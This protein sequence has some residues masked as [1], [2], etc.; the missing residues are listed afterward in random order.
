MG[1][2]KPSNPPLPLKLML[3]GIVLPGI[4]LWLA[5][6]RAHALAF[7]VSVLA[8]TTVGLIV[9]GMT[10]IDGNGHPVYWAMQMFAGLPVWLVQAM[11]LNRPPL[12]GE[13]VGVTAQ[14]IGV[15]YIAVAGMLNLLGALALGR[16][17]QVKASEE[18]AE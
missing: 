3:A 1:K 6:R 9:S 11:G 12:I 7:G 16:H 10:A 4:G 15:C 8:L 5:G 2:V 17:R 13:T 14:M 18:V